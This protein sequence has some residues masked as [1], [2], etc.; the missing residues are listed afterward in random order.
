MAQGNRQIY[1]GRP[2]TDDHRPRRGHSEESSVSHPNAAFASSFLRARAGTIGKLERSQAVPDG[3][4]G[5]EAHR[6]LKRRMLM[7]IKALWCLAAIPL[8]LGTTATA[9][10]NVLTFQFGGQLTSVN[11]PINGTFFTGQAYS[12]SFT[13]DSSAAQIRS[14]PSSATFPLL[15]AQ[16]HL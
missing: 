9:R 3:P 4:A 15:S 1:R 13:F 2:C 12:V 10:A 6:T 7:F 8:F 16:A 14:D 5:C 11:G